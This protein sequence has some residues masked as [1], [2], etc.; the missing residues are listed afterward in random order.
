VTRAKS[1]T[2]KTSKSKPFNTKLILQRP[3]PT[4]DRTELPQPRVGALIGHLT[5]MLLITDLQPLLLT[6]SLKEARQ[7]RCIKLTNATLISDKLNTKIETVRERPD[8]LTYTS[9]LI[10]TAASTTLTPPRPLLLGTEK[11]RFQRTDLL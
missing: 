5:K 2:S 1:A 11:D 3:S 9:L 8:A 10:N 6:D 7:A 4:W